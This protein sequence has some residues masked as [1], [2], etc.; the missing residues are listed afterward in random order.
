MEVGPQRIDVIDGEE[1]R[2]WEDVTVVGPR[3][4]IALFSFHKACL[5]ICWGRQGNTSLI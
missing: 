1:E 2:W 3:T 4:L 5:L